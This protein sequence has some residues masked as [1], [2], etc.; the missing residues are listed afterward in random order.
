MTGAVALLAF[1][2][3]SMYAGQHLLPR[4]DVLH[5][6][7]RLGIALWQTLAAAAIAALLL[8]MVA[9]TMPGLSA[10]AAIGEVLR[11][12]VIGIQHQYASVTGAILT[13]ASIVLLGVVGG[14]LA[15]AL[16]SQR[17]R[18]LRAR[19]AHLA[20]LEL[21][22]ERPEEGVVVLDQAAAA[23]YCVQGER[24]AGT[25]DTVVVTRG[26]LQTLTAAQ[27][28]LVLRH[29]HAH[30]S[31]HHARL[32]A[33]AHALSRAFPFIGFFR[34]AHE[35]IALLA[36]MH[37]DD[38]VA[39]DDRRSLAEALYE[40]ALANRP[41]Q[42]SVALAATGSDVVQRAQRLVGPHQPLRR[43][44]IAALS[45]AIV[46]VASTPATLAL[47]PGGVGDAHQCCLSAGDTRAAVLSPRGANT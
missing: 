11:A 44:S 4:L 15:V 40:L 30:L 20:G 43:I 2:A 25:S 10:A 34:V 38:A 37:A 9:L 24:R 36:E 41:A 35:Q 21:V 16:W 26:A 32:V 46:L 33:R 12:C 28:T 45:A 22:A 47:V 42:A 31:S 7:P 8:G 23:V 19:R 14:R 27:M 1:A 29:E 18:D 13:T 17:R 3:A 39:V 5:R 6:A